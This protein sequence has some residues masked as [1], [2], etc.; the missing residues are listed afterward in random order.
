MQNDQP[1]D[2]PV[3]YIVDDEPA[4][5]D[6]L[7]L[8]FQSVGLDYVDFPDAY[9]L[10]ASPLAI[11]SCCLV[12]DLRMPLMSGIEL[13]ETLRERG[14]AM[15]A[16]VISAHGDIKQAVRAL[17]CGATDFME[18]PFD[19]QELLDAV[20]AALKQTAKNRTFVAPGGEP[21]QPVRAQ[22]SPREA[23]VLRLVVSGY[24]NKVIARELG[25]SARTVEVHRAHIMQKFGASSVAELVRLALHGGHIEGEPAG[26][27]SNHHGISR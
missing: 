12:T 26:Y 20:H 5:R 10:L 14:V 13:V 9:A 17:K 18:K 15:P 1:P 27:L 8:L 24:A 2:R 7:G 25:I 4:V 22:L 21:V 6:A 19:D 23:E 11:G 3:V 16:I